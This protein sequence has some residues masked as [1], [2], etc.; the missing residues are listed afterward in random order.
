MTALARQTLG[1]PLLAVITLGAGSALA[2]WPTGANLLALWATPPNRGRPGL[3]GC[4][5]WLEWQA[6]PSR[7]GDLFLFSVVRTAEN[8]DKAAGTGLVRVRAGGDR[9]GRVG[10]PFGP[11]AGVEGRGNA[12]EGEGQDLVGAGDAGAAVRADGVIAVGAHAQL[13]EAAGEVGGGQ[14]GPVLVHVL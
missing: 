8:R 9:A 2:V 4:W 10:D 3:G 7:S 12:R 14:E 5:P 13:S 6:S 11:G 1:A